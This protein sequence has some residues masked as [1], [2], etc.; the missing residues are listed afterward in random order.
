MINEQ[1]V[2][3]PKN[4]SK[5]FEKNFEKHSAG[6]QITHVAPENWRGLENSLQILRLGKNS[7][8]KLP[9]DAF[10]GLS[11]LELLDLHEN[12]LKE[13]DPSVFRDG[14]AHL[15]HFYLNDNQLTNI[16]YAQL[17]SLKRLKELDLSYN[18]ISKVLQP[19]ME[20]ELRGLQMSLDILHLDYNQ[21][22]VLH[23]ESF[24][25]FYKVNKTFLN[26]N[27]L[28]YVE[29]KRREQKALNSF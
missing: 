10:I 4:K 13:I 8:D 23:T 22:E 12:C 2:N 14:M 5:N 16:P 21:I 28:V 29:V 24:Q 27:P 25:H 3:S 17:S 19:Q 20:T 11:Y 7:I 18:R 9:A 1:F 6:N 26:G 15:S